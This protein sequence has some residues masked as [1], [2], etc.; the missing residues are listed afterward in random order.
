MPKSEPAFA[1]FAIQ[2]PNSFEALSNIISEDIHRF[3]AELAYTQIVEL[4]FGERAAYLA[5]TQVT[6]AKKVMNYTYHQKLPAPYG[7]KC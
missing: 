7:T 5:R 6:R 4:P 2:G 1:Q 3:A